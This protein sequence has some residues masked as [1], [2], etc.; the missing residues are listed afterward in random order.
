MQSNSLIGQLLHVRFASHFAIVMVVVF[1]VQ[2]FCAALHNR[3]GAPV[4]NKL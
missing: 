1:F 4:A 3:A 2:F